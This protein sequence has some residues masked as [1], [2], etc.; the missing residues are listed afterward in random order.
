MYII[1]MYLMYYSQRLL[2]HSQKAFFESNSGL[3]LLSF[4]IR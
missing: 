2:M 4:V 3:F 1:C